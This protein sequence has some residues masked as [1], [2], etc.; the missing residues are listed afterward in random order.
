MALVVKKLSPGFDLRVRK[1]P[2]RRAWKPQ[3][4][5]LEKPQGK[6]SLVGYSPQSHRESDTTEVTSRTHWLPVCFRADYIDSELF[7][8]PKKPRILRDLGRK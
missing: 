1:I 6:R 2:W 4:S 7:L 8:P 3:Y 5:C